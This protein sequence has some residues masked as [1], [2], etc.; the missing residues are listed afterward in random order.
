MS[1]H[2][3]ADKS[4]GHSHWSCPMSHSTRWWGC[5]CNNCVLLA[6]CTGSH[7]LYNCS[8]PAL[9]NLGRF[10]HNLVHMSRLISCTHSHGRQKLAFVRQNTRKLGKVTSTWGSP[11]WAILS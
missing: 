4:A 3:A 2:L 8:Y 5:P 6:L 10:A 1:E 9:L 7:C 11:F